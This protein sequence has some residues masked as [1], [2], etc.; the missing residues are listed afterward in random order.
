LATNTLRHT[1]S[2]APGGLFS[3]IATID[4]SHLRISVHDQGGPNTPAPPTAAL[5]G[6]AD[7]A[8][9]S[10]SGR[11]L[12]LVSSLATAWDTRPTPTGR[13]LWFELDLA[14]DARSSPR[15]PR[16]RRRGPSPAPPTAPTHTRRSPDE[17]PDSPD[18]PRP[19]PRTRTRGAVR[20]PRR[21]L[22]PR[23]PLRPA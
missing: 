16:H 17:P 7:Q 4:A 9:L 2:G 23:P 18:P 14:T 13:T 5:P 15:R 3:V 20:T 21:P 19:G 22:Q 10:C 6:N 8:L 12:L 11:G 1:A